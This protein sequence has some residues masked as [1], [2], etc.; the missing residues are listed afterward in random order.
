MPPA[1]MIAAAWAG[2]TFAAY[3]GLVGLAASIVG[4]VIAMGINTIGSSL[5][6]FS[7]KG[8]TGS[9]PAMQPITINTTGSLNAIPV[10]YG[11]RRV[12]GTRVFVDTTDGNQ[13]LHLVFAL[14]EGQVGSIQGVYF[15]DELAAVYDPESLIENPDLLA[16]DVNGWRFNDIY[17][18]H[19][20]FEFRNGSDTQTS[21]AQ[22]TT[23]VGAEKWGTNH[24]LSGVAYLY[25]KLIYDATI[26]RT[27]LPTVNCDIIGRTV[28]AAHITAG[29]QAEDYNNPAWCLY[30]YLT[31]SRYGKGISPTLIDMDSFLHSRDYCNEL[32]EVLDSENNSFEQKRYQA[33][34]HIDTGN[35]LLDNVKNILTSMNGFLIQGSGRYK[36][37]INRDD[38]DTGNIFTFNEDNIIGSWDIQLGS[39]SN[40]FNQAKVTYYEPSAN[41]Q[42]NILLVKDAAYLADDNNQVYERELSLPLTC[43]Y[44]R[45]SYIGRIIVNQSRYQTTVSFIA[46]PTALVVE[47]G[48]IVV[49]AHPVPGWTDKLFRVMNITIQA[50]GAVRVVAAEFN[51]NVYTNNTVI[52]T[53]DFGRLGTYTGNPGGGG[54]ATFVN[55][56]SLPIISYNA[57]ATTKF[58]SFSAS[59]DTNI[60]YYEIKTSGANTL[61]LQTPTA[62][63]TYAA[64]AYVIDPTV[65]LILDAE[66]TTIVDSARYRQVSNGTNAS[67]STDQAKFG[68]KSILF[69]G[70][71]SIFWTKNTQYE[72]GAGNF[73]VE[74]WVWPTLAA[75]QECIACYAN[76]SGLNS[77]YAFE[78]LT[79]RT[80]GD[81]WQAIICQGNTAYEVRSPAG[82]AQAGVWQHV[83]LCRIDNVL[84]LY[85]NG[86]QYG[87][88][89]VTGVAVNNVA[90]AILEFGQGQGYYPFT[91][92]L[93]EVL[94]QKGVARYNGSFT[95]PTEARVWTRSQGIDTYSIRAKN[96]LGYYSK[97]ITG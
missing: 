65:S 70:A 82:T 75:Q 14:C 30:D 36:L 52:K 34:G 43:D 35:T 79:N 55:P 64:P 95:P 66:A 90:T 83:A 1:I 68:T 38:V 86:V 67:T 84:S 91:G 6:G 32:V 97:S 8:A 11:R 48:D 9:Q 21:I 10:V 56:P 4:G 69:E 74:F 72:F 16:P 31:N 13:H 12:G 89:D 7:A 28:D 54:T 60:Q 73:T 24:T 27:G 20:V 2:S 44:A 51:E 5:L 96:S 62:Y 25:V 80:D 94:I 58:V 81:Q 41:Y 93:D 33:D 46:A 76:G 59:I 42:G 18:Q 26:Y 3:I 87:G 15:N 71:G 45:A 23:A 88:L 61:V 19:C 40:R 78:I 63:T 77:N 50:D 49:I 39:K 47:V 17:D 57:S 92:Y 85:V 22:L 29:W 37:R 53:P